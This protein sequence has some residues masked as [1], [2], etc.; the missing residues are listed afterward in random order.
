MLSGVLEPPRVMLTVPSW[1][2]AE[3]GG[4]GGDG[5]FRLNG[6]AVGVDQL[7]LHVALERAVA[8]VAVGSIREQDFVEAF[9]VNGNIIFVAGVGD[10]SLIKQ[11]LGGGGFDGRGRLPGR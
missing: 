1:P 9:A 4:I 3:I 7:A 11:G 10:G 8:G 2:D 5:D 6:I